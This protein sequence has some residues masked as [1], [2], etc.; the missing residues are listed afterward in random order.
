MIFI[1]GGSYQGKT[2]FAISLYKKI[3]GPENE[4]VLLNAQDLLTA[5]KSGSGINTDT[6]NDCANCGAEGGEDCSGFI[7]EIRGADIITGFHL[8]VRYCLE[9]KKDPYKLADMILK[10]VPGA[11]IISNEIGCGIVPADKFER[12]WREAA[13]RMSCRLAASADEVYRVFCGIGQ[14]IK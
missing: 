12:E 5:A 13:G 9:R 3:N 8:L 2:E 11:V 1:T 14:R 6:G 7:E 10:E 4:P